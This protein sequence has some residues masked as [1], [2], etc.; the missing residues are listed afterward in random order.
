MVRR[1]LGYGGAVDVLTELTLPGG[2]TTTLHAA[3]SVSE[4]DPMALRR[5]VVKELTASI[6]WPSDA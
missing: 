4:S 1:P 2:G 5:Q 6:C 3:R